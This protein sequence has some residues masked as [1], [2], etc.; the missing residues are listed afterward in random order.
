VPAARVVVADRAVGRIWLFGG[1]F[2]MGIGIWSM[3]FIGMLAFSL[4]IPLRYDIPTTLTS[5]AIAIVTSSVAIKTHLGLARLGFGGIVVGAGIFAMHYS[6]MAAIQIVPMI[7][8]EPL[9]V[10]A[11]PL[12]CCVLDRRLCRALQMWIR[13]QTPPSLRVSASYSMNSDSS[14]P[15]CSSSSLVMRPPGR[16]HVIAI[17]RESN[18]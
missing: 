11:V 15:S 12:Q 17:S 8:Y 3:H 7:R 10:A 4:P 9:F 6:G 2:A 16:N 14:A 1:A 5:L 13:R 18:T